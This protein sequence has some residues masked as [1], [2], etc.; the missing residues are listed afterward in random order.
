MT[1]NTTTENRATTEEPGRTHQMLFVNLPVADP[2]A[3]RAFFTELGYGFNEEMRSDTCECLILG[4]NFF[5]M[6]LQRDFFGSFHNLQTAS[7]GN[8]EVLNCLTAESADEVD[9]LVDRAVGAGGTE[10]RG[11]QQ[12]GPDQPDF[13]YGRSFSD[14]DGHVWEVLWMDM[15]AAREAGACY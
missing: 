15:D 1:T 7:A 2:A 8:V 10:V 14:L 4:P 9:V 5:A 3:S 6:L 12:G 13:M 11:V